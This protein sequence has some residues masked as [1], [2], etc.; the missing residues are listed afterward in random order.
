[1]NF[2]NNK[3][4]F[5]LSAVILL[6]IITNA[7]TFYFFFLKDNSSLVQKSG[8]VINNELSNDQKSEGDS[9]SDKEKNN[10]KDKEKEKEKEIKDTDGDG[11][12][13]KDEEKIYKTDI[14]SVDT[15][16]DGYTDKE[17]VD[18]DHNSPVV[19]EEDKTSASG[20]IKIKW[21]DTPN[22]VSYQSIFGKQIK[23]KFIN[24][25]QNGDID[26]M[27]K[28]MD[29]AKIFQVGKIVD[30]KT[31][32]LD[33]GDKYYVASFPTM[34]PS[35]QPFVVFVKSGEEVFLLNNYSNEYKYLNFYKSLFT[36][37]DGVQI[38]NYYRPDKVDIPNS[39][40]SLIRVKS[41]FLKLAM[42]LDEPKKLFEYSNGKSV[43]KTAGGRFIIFRDDFSCEEYT[44]ELDS[45]GKEAG[46]SEYAGITPYNITIEWLDGTT[47]TKEYVFRKKI[48]PFGGYFYVDIARKALKKAGKTESGEI[49][50]VLKNKNFTRDQEKTSL[51][52]KVYDSYYSSEEKMN[53]EDFIATNPIIFW[54]DPFGDFLMF[55]NAQYVSAAELAKPVI[56]LYPEEEMDVSV[57]VKPKGGFTITEPK[58]NNGWFVNASPNGTLYNYNDKKKYE[59]LFWEGI[60]LNYEIPDKGFVVKR[61]EIK[62]FLEEKLAKL[63]LKKKEYNEFIEFWLPKMQEKP[64]YFI[65][66]LSQEQFNELAPLKVNPKPDTI[67]RVFMDFKG[68]DKKIKIENQEIK[69]SKRQGFTVIEWGGALHD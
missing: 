15:D 58:Y 38:L 4:V 55:K 31:D 11:L 9:K 47:T 60:G 61:E 44:L 34:N 52:Q 2:L 68:L 36:K 43:Y 8:D 59:Y 26:K 19:S 49:F 21:R 66:F 67:I 12:S 35:F 14:N 42:N 27:M 57:K 50:Y 63:G 5:I 25:N 28:D 69:S 51:L 17:E 23:E 3:T 65:T 53:F 40:Y 64:Y 16:G 30:E 37:L 46:D 18:S 39:Q 54:E 22:K 32:D 10:D 33:I 24:E 48:K 62:D 45:L 7:F 20:T 1:M 13:D 6:F 41:N 29:K 56:Y